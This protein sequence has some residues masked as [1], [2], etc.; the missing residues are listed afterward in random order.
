MMKSNSQMFLR[1]SLRSRT[2]P[3]AVVNL[4]SGGKRI[5]HFWCQ[6]TVLWSALNKQHGS[7]DLQSEGWT[8]YI[9]RCVA[10]ELALF[11]TDRLAPILGSKSATAAAATPAAV[12]SP[13]RGWNGFPAT[14]D[15]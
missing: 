10:E 5:E 8:S 15:S 13:T 6:I 4:N 7:T 12:R 11:P 9:N 3:R 2:I 14:P 1:P